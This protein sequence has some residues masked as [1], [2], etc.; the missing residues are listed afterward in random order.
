MLSMIKLWSQTLNKHIGPVCVTY[1][2]NNAFNLKTMFI[3][4]Y[5]S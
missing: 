3:P 2:Q 5:R 4:K 1:F